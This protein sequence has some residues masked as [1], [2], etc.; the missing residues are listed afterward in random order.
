[1]RA[2]SLGLMAG[3]ATHLSEG[4]G[5][6]WLEFIQVNHIVDFGLFLS[7]FF[8]VNSEYYS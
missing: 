2:E 1:M 7:Y 6:D 4:I 8:L 3:S 5:W